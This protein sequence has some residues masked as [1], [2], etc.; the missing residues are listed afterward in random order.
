V[1]FVSNP[2]L[3]SNMHTHQH[4]RQQQMWTALHTV[5]LALSATSCTSY[6]VLLA[7]CA[8]PCWALARSCACMTRSPRWQGRQPTS[9]AGHSWH[10]SSADGECISCWGG[11]ACCGSGWLARCWWCAACLGVVAHSAVA[12]LCSCACMT[13]CQRWLGR[14]P[15]SRAGRWWHVSSTGGEWL[16]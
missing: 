7:G 16:C 9:R 1:L 2:V 14:Q 10:T 5:V 13:R 11:A 12:H 4:G 15:T 8:Q 6:C 3:A